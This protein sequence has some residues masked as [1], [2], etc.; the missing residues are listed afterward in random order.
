MFLNSGFK[1][2]KESSYKEQYWRNLSI[3]CVHIFNNTTSAIDFVQCLWR[4]EDTLVLRI[5]AKLFK[6]E[7]VRVSVKYSLTV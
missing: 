3:D 5:H 6:H 4:K 2:K 1:K 7:E